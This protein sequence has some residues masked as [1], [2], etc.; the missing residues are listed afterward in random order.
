MKTYFVKISYTDPDQPLNRIHENYDEVPVDLSDG[1][2][3]QVEMFI[4]NRRYYVYQNF[5]V[6]FMIEVPNE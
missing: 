1:I 5:T 6:D 2:S 3:R 4:F